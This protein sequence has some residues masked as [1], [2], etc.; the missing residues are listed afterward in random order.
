MAAT[1]VAL[2]LVAAGCG[3]PDGIGV[4]DSGDGGDQ[5]GAGEL[6]PECAALEADIDGDE[7]VS[8]DEA[9][10]EDEDRPAEGDPARDPSEVNEWARTEA[11][12]D[13]AGLWIDQSAGGVVTV[14]FADDVDAHREEAQE[15]FGDDVRVVSAERTFAELQEVQEQIHEDMQAQSADATDATDPQP[16]AINST[17]VSERINRVGVGVIGGDE[18]ALAELTQRYG[19]DMICLDV[20]EPPEPM[21]PDGPVTPLAKAQ[22]W[23]DD[24][25]PN[26]VAFAVIEIAFDRET[27]ERAWDDNVPDDLPEADP[28]EA[29][30][31]VYATLDDV[32]FDE[33]AVVVWSSGES[34]SC[35]GWLADIEANDDGTVR[36]ERG[37]ASAGACTEDFNPYRMVLAVDRDR[38]PDPEDLPAEVEGAPEGRVSAY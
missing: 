20:F 17:W 13:F 38:L 31:G 6:A 7:P 15:R 35:P 1:A 19:A 26:E 23:R 29:G 21:D 24:L 16:G 10:S 33:Q 11:S 12:D 9:V 8:D 14:A 36:V 3:D 22:D 30:P 4:G 28:A 2:M 27:A 37:E 25:D 5:V 18:D 34:G 32:D